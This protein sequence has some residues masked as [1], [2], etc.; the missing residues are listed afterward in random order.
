LTIFPALPAF[1]NSTVT[2]NFLNNYTNST[3]DYNSILDN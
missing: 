1:S 2:G 3:A